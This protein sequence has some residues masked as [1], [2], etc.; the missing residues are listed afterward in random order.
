MAEN[1][2]GTGIAATVEEFLTDRLVFAGAALS[3]GA[4][5]G[6]LTFV[7]TQTKLIPW[8][9]DPV[10]VLA[11]LFLA[12]GYVRPLAGGL[13]GS[14]SM[15]VAAS[16]VAFVVHLTAWLWP[17]TLLDLTLL[18]MVF[19]PAYGGQLGQAVIAWIFAFPAF[20]TGYLTY[21]LVAGFLRP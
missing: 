3:L 19:L 6:A 7:Y 9:I 11:L 21:V 10:W 14:L 12:G 18:E 1:V 16:A 8:G 2:E 20:I 13:S 4:T 17:L 5:G 15:V